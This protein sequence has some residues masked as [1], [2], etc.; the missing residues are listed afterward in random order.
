MAHDDQVWAEQDLLLAAQDAGRDAA[1]AGESFAMGSAAPARAQ[2]AAQQDLGYA[3]AGDEGGAGETGSTQERGLQISI[4]GVF[5]E[6]G[7]FKSAVRV[8]GGTFRETTYAVDRGLYTEI[9][10]ERTLRGSFELQTWASPFADLAVYYGT[11]SI[12]SYVPIQVRGIVVRNDNA[13]VFYYWPYTP[14]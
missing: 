1:Q 10:R 3:G 14:R 6:S 12:Q 13:G 7:A 9:L 2:Q 8:T 5:T 11:V 4:G